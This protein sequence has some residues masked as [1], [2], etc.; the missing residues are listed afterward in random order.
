MKIDDHE[1]EVLFNNFPDEAIK[2]FNRCGSWAGRCPDGF[3][4][5]LMEYDVKRVRKALEAS[6]HGRDD[7]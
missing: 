7:Y 4:R 6:L 2:Q 1:R 3:W 5:Q